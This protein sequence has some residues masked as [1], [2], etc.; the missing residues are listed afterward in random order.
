MQWFFGSPFRSP[1]AEATTLSA[2]R[3]LLEL[4]GPKYRSN[5]PPGIEFSETQLYEGAKEYLLA[6]LNSNPTYLHR[7]RILCQNGNPLV[8]FDLAIA[9]CARDPA[10]LLSV[11]HWMVAGLIRMLRQR[12]G[13]IPRG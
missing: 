8:S 11:Q 1:H 4:G 9:K 13:E 12:N 10:M 3:E 2:L 5:I 6:A 7:S